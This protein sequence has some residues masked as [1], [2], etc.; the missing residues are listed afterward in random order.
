[1]AGGAGAHCALLFAMPE[2]GRVET[3]RG[4]QGSSGRPSAEHE[5]LRGPSRTPGL[6]WEQ[7]STEA[8]SQKGGLKMGEATY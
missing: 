7:K 3:A 4:A 1:M 8:T 5:G 2:R 6:F